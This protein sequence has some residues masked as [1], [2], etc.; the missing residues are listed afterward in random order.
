MTLETQQSLPSGPSRPSRPSWS[1]TSKAPAIGTRDLIIPT[2]I[3]EFPVCL[4]RWKDKGEDGLASE[5]EVVDE[6]RTFVRPTWRPTLSEFCTELTGITQVCLKWIQ[7]PL[8][9]EMLAQLHQF[10]M[11]NEL[12]DEHGQSL[13]TVPF[14]VR[15]FVVKQ[16]FI[17]KVRVPS[18]LQGDILDVRT[19]V[20]KHLTLLHPPDKSKTKKQNS[21]RVGVFSAAT[22]LRTF[23][24]LMGLVTQPWASATR[25][26]M[27]IAAQLK[28]LDL[29]E[30]AGREH[31]GIDDAR[32]ITRVLA[33]LARKGTPLQP[34]T[35]I[36][37]LRR[38]PWMGPRRGEILEENLII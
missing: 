9:P 3:I 18:W 14:D 30:F 1:L 29:S 8:F 33:A 24:V 11:K 38:W 26:T 31:S 25:R 21:K 32:N 22:V 15:D 7:A 6:F 2:E 34:N 23:V 4:M 17:S 37:P 10:L 20:L 27:N 13:A 19:L 12:L 28:A 36:Q 5:L 16:C 35:P